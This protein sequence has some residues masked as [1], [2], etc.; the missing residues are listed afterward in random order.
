LNAIVH[1]DG[2]KTLPCAVKNP[3]RCQALLQD[4]PMEAWQWLA[5]EW[6]LGSLTRMTYKRTI[7]T[8]RA[9]R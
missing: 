9:T 8:E 6:R 7:D 4:V 1:K 3:S 2:A 5:R